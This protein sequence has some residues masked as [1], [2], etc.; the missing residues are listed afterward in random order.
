[1]FQVFGQREKKYIVVSCTSKFLT[2]G[3][4]EVESPLIQHLRQRVDPLPFL[5]LFVCL[6]SVGGFTELNRI[7][8]KSMSQFFVPHSYFF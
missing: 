7:K 3:M 2:L 8:P 5:S 6:F 1:M 4:G